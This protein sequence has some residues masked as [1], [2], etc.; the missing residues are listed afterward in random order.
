M[1]CGCSTVDDMVALDEFVP[2]V[3]PSVPEAPEEMVAHYV[4]MAAIDFCR[5]THVVKATVTFDLQKGVSDYCFDCI[6]GLKPFTLNSVCVG[7]SKIPALR[8]TPCPGPRCAYGY[9]YNGEYDVLVFPAPKCD[10]PKGLSIEAVMQPDQDACE[11]PR[12]LYEQYAEALADGALHRML[13]L[14]TSDWFNASVAG[15]HM[16][17][18]IN[19][20]TQA[21]LLVARRNVNG[22]LIAQA[23][24]WI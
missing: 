20:V 7:S 22:P 21:K 5:K 14:P 1:T 6:E 2:Y 3:L 4:R 12:I 17:R 18:Y 10:V 16:R 11:L 24:R 9:S 8:E 23:P 13:S 19:A 15:V